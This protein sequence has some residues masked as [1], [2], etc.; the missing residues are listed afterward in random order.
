[1]TTEPTDTILSRGEKE[2]LIRGNLEALERDL[3]EGRLVFESK[4]RVVEWQ[5]SNFCNMSCT[6][7]Y[8]GDNPPLKKMP[9]P[10]VERIASEVLP[11]ASILQPF[12]GSEPLVLTWDH[13]LSLTARYDLDLDIITNVQ[14][15]DEAK[16]AQLEPYVSTITFSIDSHIE[17]VY[18][19]IRLRA[20]TKK[21]FENLPV[22]AK[23]CYE[24]GI[25]TEL[26]IVFMTEN[27]AFLDESVAYFADAGVRT[28]R[29]L[30]YIDIVPGR[31]M[32][33]AFRSMKPAWIESMKQ[34][35]I[36]VAEEKRIQVI[37]IFDEVDYYD[38]RLP[39]PNQRKDRK[40]NL[41]FERFKCFYPGYCRQSLELL[42]IDAGGES[43]PC[44]VTPG[45]ELM[46]G[47]V[48]E[49]PVDEVWNG[50][51]AQDLR[52]AMMTG[53][54][55]AVCRG[56]KD[57]VHQ[58]I[59]AQQ[60]MPFVD[61][62]AGEHTAGDLLPDRRILE[63]DG[64]AHLA[65]EVEPPTL[66]WTPP[67]E[68]VDYYVIGLAMGGE[69]HPDNLTVRCPA[70]Q[71]EWRFP[72]DAWAALR[73]NIGYWW[74]VWGINESDPSASVRAPAIRCLRRHRAMPR[75]AGSTLRY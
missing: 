7:C 73:P 43:F 52:R 26:N 48:T 71:T 32:S 18:E 34:K 8:D 28:V 27:A 53:D 60:H 22:A 56:C 9:E 66:S 69:Q 10:V 1:M 36:R 40:N 64:P 55:P 61:P 51:E 4:P 42:R 38:Y 31:E 41:W 16:F 46:L 70:D 2:Q 19:R 44:C 49:S 63:V 3:L 13:T 45:D 23:L 30:K 58:A 12:F 33:D 74:T 25:E 59:A 75:M 24:H 11:S 72:D 37:F 68:H 39:N 15:L 20:N 57:L 17:G 62:V 29:I 14:F 67:S 65:R 54:L 47:N 21:V 6:M 35:I 5:F 50:T